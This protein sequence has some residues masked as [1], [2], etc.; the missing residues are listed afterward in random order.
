MGTPLFGHAVD[1]NFHDILQIGN[2]GAGLQSGVYYALLDGAANATALSISTIGVEI[3]G[4]L[5]V[6]ALSGILAAAGGVV[7]TNSVLNPT[8]TLPTSGIAADMVD[9]GIFYSPVTPVITSITPNTAYLNGNVPCVVRGTGFL[10]MRSVH[11]GAQQAM[12][13]HII[14]DTKMIVVPFPVSASGAVNLV[15]NCA[16]GTSATLAGGFTFNSKSTPGSTT[17]IS[18]TVSASYGFGMACLGNDLNLWWSAFY[19][20][21]WNVT[22]GGTA[23]AFAIG[24]NEIG[25]SIFAGPGGNLW[26]TSY[27]TTAL[28]GSIWKIPPNGNTPTQYLLDGADASTVFT[29]P[30]CLGSD[31]NMYVFATGG[32]KSYL[33]RVPDTVQ[34]SGDITR[35]DYSSLGFVASPG[36]F[37]GPNLNLYI[38]TLS[39]KLVQLSNNG[40][41]ISSVAVPGATELNCGCVG[42]DGN[43]WLGDVGASNGGVIRVSP[44]NISGATRFALAN[45]LSK[46]PNQLCAGSDGQIWVIA[47]NGAN[48]V[49]PQKTAIISQ[50]NVSTG[51]ETQ[52]S[53]VTSDAYIGS[54]T[55]IAV[56]VNGNL[57]ATTYQYTPASGH[58]PNS[59]DGFLIKLPM[60]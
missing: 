34:S 55:G 60:T 33:W 59:L 27:N 46:Q 15:V 7:S 23:T 50:I 44:N 49:S 42:C 30:G 54:P 38:P 6:G 51:T 57:I 53:Y 14:N 26:A 16:G 40:T 1:A 17:R 18:T 43:I 56:D 22:P 28:T 24:T 9:A 2:S 58:N 36:I 5:T 35:Y 52:Y 39:G 37:V 20:A 31:G 32:G 41:L 29:G 13:A 47:S 25:V 11:F 4:T 8:R 3:A 45:A 48:P 12:S 21:M 10:T 19:A